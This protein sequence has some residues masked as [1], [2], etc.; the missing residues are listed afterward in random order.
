MNYSVA[1]RTLGTSVTLNKELRSLFA[2]TQPPEKIVI[3]IA[4]GYKRP[5]FQ[6]GNEQYVW[7]KKGMIAQRALKYDEIDSEYLLLLDDDVELATDSVER[8]LNAMKENNADCVGADTFKNQDMSFIEKTYAAVTNLVFPHWS[9]RWAF[10]IHRNG[11][12]S[13]NNTPNGGFYESQ[14]CAGPCSLWKKEALLKLHWEDETWLEE[15]GFAYGDDALEFY[16]L[17]ANGGKLGILYDSGVKNLDGKTASGGF[18]KDIKKFYVRSFASLAIWHRTIYKCQKDFI[19]K[20][21]C[22]IDFGIKALWLLLINIVAGSAMRK[23]KVPYYY[24]LGLIDA[25]KYVSSEE[26]RNIPPYIITG[27]QP[28]DLCFQT[29]FASEFVVKG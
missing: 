7:I 14:S 27:K 23:I 18:Q 17:Y 25:I 20:T 10:K 2:Q 13:Y 26:Y 3:Y 16:K 1:I 8:M 21:I 11:S 24:V 22:A 5:E 12:F 19:N 6:I 29:K 28:K 4:E 15:L 9:N